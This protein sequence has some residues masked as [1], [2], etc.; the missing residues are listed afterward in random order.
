MHDSIKPA[1]V[2]RLFAAVVLLFFS[3]IGCGQRQ[4]DAV[5]RIQDTLKNVR[6]NIYPDNRGIHAK[7]RFQIISAL[8]HATPESIKSPVLCGAVIWPAGPDEMWDVNYWVVAESV[9]A[10]GIILRWT[11]NA[12]GTY[13][14][15]PEG[16]PS[17]AQ[18][19]MAQYKQVYYPLI[20]R[21]STTKLREI[22]VPSSGIEAALARNGVAIS[23]F[24]DCDSFFPE[25]EIATTRMDEKQQ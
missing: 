16:L 21:L 17:V 9:T 1:K 18:Q 12:E 8:E 24:V 22:G 23:K 13:I 14:K 25:P 5:A 6:Q 19:E 3:A 20:T 2:A 4:D 11:G 10:D 15:A 7:I